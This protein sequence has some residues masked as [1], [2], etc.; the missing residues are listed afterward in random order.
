[1]KKGLLLVALMG[2][3]CT[4]S[5]QSAFKQGQNEISVGLGLGS[6]F[7]GT[8]FKASL[9]VNPQVSFERAFTDE[10]SIGGT[11]SYA[12]SKYD[13]SSFGSDYSI[14]YNALFVG[15]RGAYHFPVNS[16]FDPYLGASL[17]YVVVSV[18]DNQGS[19]A[20]AASGI[21][22]GAFAGAKYFF[23]ENIGAYAEL[24]YSSLSLLSLGITLKF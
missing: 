15:A 3:A 21:G 2:L 11:V 5:S 13:Y 4:V 16:K 10:L 23:Q 24:G 14:K 1:M 20:A 6:P 19:T 18:S 22:Y 7:W 9:P 12:S 17:G 8:G